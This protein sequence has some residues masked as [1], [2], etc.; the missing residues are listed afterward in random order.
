MMVQ[1]TKV[2]MPKKQKKKLLLDVQENSGDEESELLHMQEGL[3]L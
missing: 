1:A 2:K 3:F